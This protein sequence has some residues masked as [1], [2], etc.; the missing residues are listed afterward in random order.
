MK[1]RATSDN[2]NAVGLFPFL[3]VLL[4]TMGAL[5]VLLVVLAQN[6]GM[7]SA[8]DLSTSAPFVVET[9]QPTEEERETADAINQE[10]ATISDYRQQLRSL[11]Q[12][13]EVRLRD[14][15]QRLSHLEEHT[16]RLEHELAELSLAA[17]QLE[18]T[19]ENQS[20]DRQQAE[21]ELQRLEQLVGDKKEQL[22]N[23]REETTGKRS[24][25]IVPYQGRN[26]TYRKPIYIE[27]SG[28]GIVLHPEGVRLQPSDFAATSWPGNPLASALRASRE[29]LNAKAARAGEPEPPDPYPLILVRPDGIEQYSAARS[30]I[31]SWDADFGYEFIDADWEL[32]FPDLPDPQ[33]AQ[34]QQ[35]AIMIARERLVRLAQS[36]PR[37]FGS[38]GGGVG[39]GRSQG[40][41]SGE[42]WGNAEAARGLV[43][44][45]NQG[46]SST[47]NGLTAG[48]Q[49]HQAQSNS[50]SNSEADKRDFQFG[51]SPANASLGQASINGSPQGQFEGP[52]TTQLGTAEGSGNPFAEGGGQGASASA[53]PNSLTS[54]A[55]A[56]QGSPNGSSSSSFGSSSNPGSANPS[57]PQA[58]IAATRGR[59]WA[60]GRARGAVPIRRPIQVVV[61][62]N[63]IS[64]LP[65]RHATRGAE[66]TGS[67]VLLNQSPN[68]VS[69]QFVAALKERIG[70][71]GLAGNGLY[72]RPVLDLHVGPN[73]GP[74]ASQL[75]RLL[76]D[77]GVEVRV[78]QTAQANPGGRANAPQSN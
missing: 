30:A 78:P 17:Q 48:A 69:K 64:L 63:Q 21:R 54:Q 1:K 23:L 68:Q 77:S 28:E 72:W 32:S 52:E 56:N 37:R 7:R 43:A 46:T 24:Y 66:A 5:L 22:E 61:R 67:V 2:S 60:V 6:A 42:Q 20:I 40:S 75:I 14:E 76:K 11:K 34:A 53:N 33:L 58:S 51:G 57:G 18:A 26:G 15:Q 47:G 70:E 8:R 39:R 27:C 35:H 13:G 62:E 10:L 59:G 71:W 50:R 38:I 16:R 25:A 41:A 74:T 12:Q 45:S 55:N 36:A 3:A 4:C 73:A 9:L 29:Y 65:S 49:T 44:Q 31:T 19:E